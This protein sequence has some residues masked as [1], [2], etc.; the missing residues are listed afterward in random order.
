[1][2]KCPT[3]KK[4]TDY[5]PPYLEKKKGLIH[6]E[7][8]ECDPCRRKRIESKW[9]YSKTYRVTVLQKGGPGRRSKSTTSI[10]IF[11]TPNIPILPPRNQD[12]FY[13]DVNEFATELYWIKKGTK[14]TL[15]FYWDE[16]KVLR[17]RHI[18][19]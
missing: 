14:I 15:S 2:S 8:L 16:Y 12:Y 11:F 6:V 3:C 13:V 17:L 5:G 1:M 18:G 9:K 19:V 4:I 10:P 7:E